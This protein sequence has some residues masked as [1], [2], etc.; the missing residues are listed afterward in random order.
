MIPVAVGSLGTLKKGMVE[1]IK[2]VSE[3]AAVTEIQ[4]LC[5]MRSAR[6]K[7]QKGA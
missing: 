2:K 7:P 6:I 4:N 3:A 5:M 1:N